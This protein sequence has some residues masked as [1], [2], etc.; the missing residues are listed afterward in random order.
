MLELGISKHDPVL[1]YDDTPIEKDTFFTV[2]NK[3]DPY[4]PDQVWNMQVFSLLDHWM[5]VIYLSEPKR[6]Y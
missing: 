1:E 4:T 6:E 3:S 5:K 2:L